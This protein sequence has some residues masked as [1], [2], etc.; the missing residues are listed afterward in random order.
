MGQNRERGHLPH[1]H[2]LCVLPWSH[3]YQ[4][5]WGRKSGWRN[6]LITGLLY[7]QSLELMPLRVPRGWGVSLSPQQAMLS[8]ACQPPS[9]WSGLQLHTPVP[10]LPRST[11]CCHHFLCD[12]AASLP[13]VPSN[14]C[15]TCRP[16]C[17]FSPFRT[18]QPLGKSY[19]GNCQPHFLLWS[20]QSSA[21]DLL[22]VW[23]W[24]AHY[25]KGEIFH[26]PER[27]WQGQE[28]EMRNF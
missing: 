25:N 16:L 3:R 27:A 9:L 13:A 24:S 12:H 17:S 8:F 4:C 14:H 6:W 26:W 19:P 11:C 22:L 28:R 10:P 21:P 1:F 2:S 18:R 15:S 5:K 23:M 20:A 7:F